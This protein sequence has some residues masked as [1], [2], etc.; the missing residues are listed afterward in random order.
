MYT[1]P[2]KNTFYQNTF[3][4]GET[5]TTRV[6]YCWFFCQGCPPW[7]RSIGGYLLWRYFLNI[8]LSGCYGQCQ[9]LKLNEISSR[10]YHKKSI[11]GHSE[12]FWKKKFGWKWGGSQYLAIFRQFLDFE[13]CLTF[14]GAK[15]HFFSKS[16]Q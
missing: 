3:I 4:D 10:K 2:N 13:K 11:S 14:L 1:K 8:H 9:V 6:K 12:S 7:S 5:E 15:K 16:A